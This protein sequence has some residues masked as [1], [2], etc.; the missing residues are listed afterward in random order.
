MFFQRSDFVDRLSEQLDGSSVQKLAEKMTIYNITET[1]TR[2][3][4]TGDTYA[5]L[6]KILEHSTEKNKNTELS[7]LGDYLY[8]KFDS[9][10]IILLCSQLLQR[11]HDK[12]N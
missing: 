8:E 9:K 1:L 11:V 7:I 2:K 12:P 4:T 10:D 5:V 3:M 6:K